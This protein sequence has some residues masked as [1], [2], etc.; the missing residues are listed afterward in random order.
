[1]SYWISLQSKTCGTSLEHLWDDGGTLRELRTSRTRRQ[2][3]SATEVVY[4]VGSRRSVQSKRK[5]NTLPREVRSS[6]SRKWFCERE[7]ERETVRGGGRGGGSVRRLIVTASAVRSSPILVTLMK[8][9]LSSSETSVLIRA[10]RRNIPEYTI[11]QSTLSPLSVCNLVDVQRKHDL[12]FP[13]LP[14]P[15]INLS[16]PV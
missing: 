4:T 10:S 2:H 11:L 9:A 16:L 1:M 7:R 5:L 3:Y 12:S 6:A 15:S 14:F 8:E 13:T